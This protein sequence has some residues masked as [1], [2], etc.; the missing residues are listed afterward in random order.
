M[1][2]QN[3]VGGLDGYRNALSTVRRNCKLM[4][5]DFIAVQH[6]CLDQEKLLD[7]WI[8]AQPQLPYRGGPNP[9]VAQTPT[10]L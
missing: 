9:Y 2:L 10:L 4:F 3:I 7:M 8:N 5:D 6:T 1:R